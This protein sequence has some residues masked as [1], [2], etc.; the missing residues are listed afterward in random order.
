[1]IKKKESFKKNLQATLEKSKDK[2][3][4]LDPLYTSM[5]F[6]DRLNKL[7]YGQRVMRSLEESKK[8][9]IQYMSSGLMLPEDSDKLIEFLFSR[10]AP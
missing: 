2:N 10:Y 3:I 6:A 1:M 4:T 9:Y 7:T 8:I 5:D